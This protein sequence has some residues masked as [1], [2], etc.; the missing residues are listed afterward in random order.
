VT[1]L[2]VS[3]EEF[4]VLAGRVTQLAAELYERLEAARA[5]PQT[6]GTQTQQAFDEPAP[7]EGLKA[8]A[9]DALTQVVEMSRL[10]T[11]RFFGYVLGSGEPVAALADLL[12]S[13]LNQN[14]TSWRSAPAAA[15]I[16]RQVVH[17]IAEALGCSEL[18][19]SLCG[20][21]SSANLMALAMAREAK[22][23]G[24]D[25]GA[26][27]GVIYCSGEAHMSIAKAVALL[28]LGRRSLHAVPVDARARMSV[29]G[30]E[31]A[32]A[33]DH[34]AGRDRIAVVAS[35]GTVSTGAIDPLEDI[36]EICRANGLWLHVD[37]AYGALGALVA[38]EKYRGLERADSLSVD[39]HKWL[40]QPV[41]CGLL[42]FKDAAVARRTFSHTEDYARVI[43]SGP[44]EDFAF[45]EESLELSRR[46]RALKVWLSLRYH[47]LE[48]FRAAIRSD[49]EHAQ[50]LGDAVRECPELELLAPVELSAVC[51][52]Y[53]GT[54][55]G[56]DLNQLNTAI[57][58][59]I[60][61][62]GRVYLSN[63]S[64]AGAFALRAC[65]VNH[66]SRSSDV[67]EIVPEVLKAARSISMQRR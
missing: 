56:P 58:R 28:G 5:Y 37:G 39:L 14:V 34:A 4:R 32:I 7:Q 17:W 42:L 26:R 8:A 66:R 9:L 65:F 55:G 3:P 50:Q 19:G 40:Y 61:E 25:A 60:I 63:A 67:A 47:G 44:D 45:F 24:N 30:L 43:D 57:L 49:L 54:D 36:A 12:A 13:V 59:R 64:I 38:A 11:S 29:S 23:P 62:N 41:D 1:A 15:A 2:H 22:L 52:R 35:A 31:R 48:A 46:F 33:A 18:T 10:P 20:G 6:S 53:R 16:E 27:P 51:F 21:G